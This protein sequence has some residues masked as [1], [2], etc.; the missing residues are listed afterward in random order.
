MTFCLM[1]LKQFVGK[2]PVLQSHPLEKRLRDAKL[3]FYLLSETDRYHFCF[4]GFS[5]DSFRLVLQ[6]LGERGI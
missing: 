2:Q 6:Q 1:I 3:L 4:S 5:V